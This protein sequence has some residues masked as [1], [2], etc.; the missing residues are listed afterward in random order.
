MTPCLRRLA[1]IALM[2][3]S[4]HRPSISADEPPAVGLE[5]FAGA[6][7][8][9]Q[10]AVEPS[11]VE[12]NG[13]KA[14]QINGGSAADDTTVLWWKDPP[15]RLLSGEKYN[16]SV[17]VKTEGV[18]RVELKVAVPEGVELTGLQDEKLTGTSD[19]RKLEQTFSV[20]QD[21]QPKHFA[22]WLTGGGKAWA[23]DFRLGGKV[24]AEWQKR[25]EI[26]PTGITTE[27]AFLD[28]L[29][30]NGL[31]TAGY[32]NYFTGRWPYISFI[33]GMAMGNNSEDLEFFY[34]KPF[35]WWNHVLDYVM[36]GG[37]RKFGIR[38]KIHRYK[39]QPTPAAMRSFLFT[40]RTDRLLPEY[41]PSY[42]Y[43]NGRKVWDAKQ[44]PIQNGKLGPVEHRERHR[45]ISHERI[46]VPLQ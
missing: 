28:L 17:W 45:I 6:C 8:R 16:A 24:G 25:I 41:H 9:A 37:G 42:I 23:E 21:A 22:V 20:S 4:L 7:W 31:V 13:R 46:V 27:G 43:A 1:V 29:K 30:Q 2:A 26:D 38:A 34:E 11:D 5:R 40:L 18:G 32:T 36:E 44:H 3:V 19:W 12:H 35:K 39:E 10:P 15:I 33:G 14:V